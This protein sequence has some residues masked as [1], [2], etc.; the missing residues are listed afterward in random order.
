MLIGEKKEK[1]RRKVLFS[2]FARIEQALDE[3]VPRRCRAKF[4]SMTPMTPMTQGDNSQKRLSSPKPLR[5]KG[6]GHLMTK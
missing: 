6:F 2:G 1:K 5:C 3:A 4:G